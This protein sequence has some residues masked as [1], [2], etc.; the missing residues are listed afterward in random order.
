MLFDHQDVPN[1][2][3]F[4]STPQ[5]GFP[6]GDSPKIPISHAAPTKARSKKTQS[7]KPKL[8]TTALLF[9]S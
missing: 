6:A 7:R 1:R 2:T 5:N 8:A 4:D 9:S 3:N